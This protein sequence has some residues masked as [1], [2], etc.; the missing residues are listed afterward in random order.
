MC[1][2]QSPPRTATAHAVQAGKRVVLASSFPGGPRDQTQRFQDGIAVV[3]KK[4]SPSLFV[5][6]TCNPKWREIVENLGPNQSASDRPD[7]VACVFKLKLDSLLAELTKKGIFGR[8]V[9]FLHVIEFQKRG[10]PHAHILIILEKAIATVD[11]ID[12]CV[13]AELPT[14]PNASDY[15]GG[16]AGEPYRAAFTRWA[17]LSDAVCEFMTHGPCG[18]ANPHAP[19]MTDG[20]CKKNFPKKYQHETRKPEDAIYPVYRRRS[21]SDGGTRRT[22]LGHTYDNSHVVPYSP[23]LLL[24]YRCH[25]NVECCISVKG[26]KCAC[27]L[28]SALSPCGYSLAPL[29]TPHPPFLLLPLAP[30][31]V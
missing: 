27:S 7:L 13:C 9:A 28:P 2:T 21:P 10:L 3:R 23:Y 18:D 16:E 17:E 6:M 22:Y 26:I 25:L 29:A 19:C 4:H 30:F 1:A 12:Q 5:T 24:K 15:E 14:P 20:K 31:S 11:E 8:T